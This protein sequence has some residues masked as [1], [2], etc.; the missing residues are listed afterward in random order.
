MFKTE[1]F[2]VWTIS[3]Q[4]CEVSVEINDVTAVF[5]MWDWYDYDEEKRH[6]ALQQLATILNLG[7]TFE[8]IE[9]HMK[10]NG[11]DCKLKEL[12]YDQPQQTEEAVR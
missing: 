8:Q 9:R 1:D 11:I 12:Q 7:G 10:M 3:G 6:F 4:P 5:V 2:N